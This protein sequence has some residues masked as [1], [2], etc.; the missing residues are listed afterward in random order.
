MFS[1]DYMIF[2][3]LSSGGIVVFEEEKVVTLVFSI[4]SES[5]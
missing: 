3:R 4:A 5:D 2:Y 1:I